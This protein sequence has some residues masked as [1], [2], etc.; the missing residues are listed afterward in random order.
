MCPGISS[1]R[2]SQV[3]AIWDQACCDR[4]IAG[5][6][7]ETL[8]HVQGILSTNNHREKEEVIVA[9]LTVA[10]ISENLKSSTDANRLTRQIR[11]D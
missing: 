2:A 1:S 5:L 6:A 9:F 7:D 10:E 4:F 8:Q 3:L 11:G